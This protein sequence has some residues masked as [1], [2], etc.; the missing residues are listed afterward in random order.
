MDRLRMLL[1][2]TVPLTLAALLLTVGGGAA[3][4]AAPTCNFGNGIKHLILIQFDNVHLRRDNPNVP[5]DLEQMPN[6]L[7]FMLNNGTVSGNHHTPLISHTANDILT[8]LTGVYPDRHGIPVA[9][10]YRVFDSSNH[11]SSSHPSFIYWT[12]TDSTDAKPVLLNEI[13][14]NAPAPWVP[15]TRAGCD[16]GAFS[17]ANIEFET[18]PG[19]VGVAFGTNSPEFATVQSELASSDPAIRQSANTDWLGIAVHCAQGSKLC[20]NGK[21]DLLPDEP[22]P[23]GQAAPNQ[24][25][26]FKALFGNIN[27]QPAISQTGPVK[28]L[29]GNVIADAFGHPGFPNTFSPTA[30]QTLGYVSSMLEAGIPI[31]YA[32]IAD[33]HDNRSGSGTFGPGEVGYVAQLQAY[34]K[35]WGQFFA[36]LEA[37]GLNKT[38]TLFIFTADEND[39]F[40]GGSPTPANCDGVTTPCTYVYPGTSPPVRSVGELTTNLDSILL[41]QRGDQ[42]AFLVH[43]DDAPTIYIDGKPG[44]TDAVTRQFEF[45]LAQLT[46][47]NPLPGK[48]GQVD[49]LAQYL[50]DQAEMKLLHMVTS[51]PARTPTLTMFGDPDYFF[52]TTKGALPLAPQNCGTNNVVCVSQNNLFAWNHG[53]VQ[54][55]ITRTW[56]GMVGPGV[57]IQ[58]RD[59]SVFSDHTDLRPTALLLLRLKDDYMHDGRA[60]V[61]KVEPR[62]VP[63]SVSR[64]DKDEDSDFLEL[65]QVYK[66]ITAP[67]GQ[68]ARTSLRLAAR[69]IAGTDTAY[70][71]FLS[72]IG[73]ITTERDEL[74]GEIR[75]AVDGAEFGNRSIR[76]FHPD[77]LI[78]RARA[79]IDKVE[80]LER[81]SR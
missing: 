21:P 29:D 50:A 52:Q 41:T 35:A 25:V 33:A 40:V 69:S 71:W 27:V 14:K 43:A 57:R 11:P 80:D 38:N 17:I 77:Q 22:G 51:S 26:G 44:P 2:P 24:Y 20:A 6:L 13:G 10:S 59:D 63:A 70:A 81:R 76:D 49:K 16:F 55:E 15:F 47:V 74:A 79:L 23:Q 9:N 67:L 68:L 5:S 4:A 34:D 36:R 61:E 1:G 64:G 75:Q 73:P 19:D 37:H 53:D 65:V 54:Q 8:T 31:V 78:R 72:E 62:V 12:A 66:Q 7:N 48:T 18:L 3:K 60:L 32:Y 42:T 45:D 46:W 28:D 58:G 39:H 30:T 56:F